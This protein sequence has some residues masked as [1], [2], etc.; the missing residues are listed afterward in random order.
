[1]ARGALLTLVREG[2][3]GISESVLRAGTGSVANYELLS[4]ARQGSIEGKKGPS[5]EAAAPLNALA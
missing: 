3:P 2:L 5:S 1:M 4:C